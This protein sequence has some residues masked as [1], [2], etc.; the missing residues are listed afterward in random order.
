MHTILQKKIL[1]STFGARMQMC[2]EAKFLEEELLSQG[3]C[4]FN[5][6]VILTNCQSSKSSL[7]PGLFQALGLFSTF[8]TV[9]LLL[10]YPSPWGI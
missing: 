8:S 2:L 1:V 5:I 7:V 9:V 10:K 6:L 4:I 3:A